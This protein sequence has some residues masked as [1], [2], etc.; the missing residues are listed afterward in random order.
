MI[1]TADTY[2]LFS[3]DGSLQKFTLVHAAQ[4]TLQRTAPYAGHRAATWWEART[5]ELVE[6][7]VGEDGRDGASPGA[8]GEHPGGEHRQRAWGIN[9]AM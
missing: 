5:E 3:L 4:E 1:T 9:I 2:A 6:C 7:F 8:L